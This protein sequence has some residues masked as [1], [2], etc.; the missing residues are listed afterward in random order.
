MSD[1]W[2]DMKKAKKEVEE[3]VNKLNIDPEKYAGSIAAEYTNW[4]R[5][6]IVAKRYSFDEYSKLEIPA[7]PGLFSI[8]YVQSGMVTLTVGDRKDTIASGYGAGITSNTEYII[9]AK[10]GVE[11]V[12]GMI[13]FGLGSIFSYGTTPLFVNFGAPFLNIKVKGFEIFNCKSEMGTEIYHNIDSILDFMNEKPYGYELMVKAKMCELWYMVVR[14]F[15]RVTPV[16]DI[17]STRKDE[18]RIRQAME[19]IQMHYMEQITLEDIS[20][21]INVCKSECCR[22]FK[23]VLDLTPIEYVVRYRVYTAAFLIN[24]PSRNRDEIA[25]IAISVGFNNISYFN[26]MFKKYIGETPTEYKKRMADDEKINELRKNQT[27]L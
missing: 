13:F 11:T 3:L 18:L 2:C 22:C 19:Y 21:N 15:T 26:K 25:T 12:I 9:T 6:P 7:I 5:Q 23:R 27:T 17:K 14:A 8:F 20:N 16:R 4:V 1:T 24:D 10:R